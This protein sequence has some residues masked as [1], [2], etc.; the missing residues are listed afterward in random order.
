MVQ[1]NGGK[2][3]AEFG[4]QHSINVEGEFP[5]EYKKIKKLPGIGPYKEDPGVSDDELRFE[6][7]KFIYLYRNPYKD[8]TY[9]KNVQECIRD[10]VAA[11]PLIDNVVLGL[12]KLDTGH[13]EMLLRVQNRVFT[14]AAGTDN[15][16][17]MSKLDE[18]SSLLKFV[19]G[20]LATI[21][22]TI[23][24]GRGHPR[25]PYGSPTFSL[26]L[27]WT[28]LTGQSVPIP[29]GRVK[30]KD[31][32][33]EFTQPSTEFIRLGLKMIISKISLSNVE[34]LIKNRLAIKKHYDKF[35]RRHPGQEDYYEYVLPMLQDAVQEVVQSQ[36]KRKKRSL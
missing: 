22:D 30:G 12:K 13:L 35:V 3:R 26:M 9:I 27:A 23:S 20:F 2:K 5:D 17:I 4:L 21:F 1:S 31:G 24:G 7:G 8:K 18:A 34:T 19:Y 14:E 11:K 6:L 15:V 29:K 10:A 28:N 33:Y 32:T 36:K 25:L 16:S